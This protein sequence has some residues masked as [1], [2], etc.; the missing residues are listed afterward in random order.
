MRLVAHLEHIFPVHQPKAAVGCLQTQ[1]LNPKT[2]T[3]NLQ[4]IFESN[5]E[6]VAAPPH[7]GMTFQAHPSAGHTQQKLL[8]H[9]CP[10]EN[11]PGAPRSAGQTQQKSTGHSLSYLTRRTGKL[12]P[13]CDHK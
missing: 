8:G 6:P 9:S 1:T 11:L 2:Q 3:L 4:H 10:I 12:D 7:Q 5:E 13:I